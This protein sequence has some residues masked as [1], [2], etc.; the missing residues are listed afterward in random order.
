MLKIISIV[1][2]VLVAA[3][4]CAAL[5]LTYWPDPIF[6]NAPSLMPEQVEAIK[7]ASN[8]NAQSFTF[9]ER[10]FAVRD[11][12]EIFARVFGAQSH[13]TILL[14]HGVASDGAALIRPAGLLRDATSARVIAID[15]RGHGNSSGPAWDLDHVGKYDDDLADI[16][17]VLRK[18]DP[19]AKIILA[20]H[21][22]GGGIVLRYALKSDAP[23]IDGYLLFAPLLGTG[24]PTMRTQGTAGNASNGANF[25]HFRAPRLF[26]VLMLNLVGIQALN[27]LPILYFNQPPKYPAYGF[28]ALSS[29]QPNAPK[30]YRAAFAAIKAP[31]LLVAGSKDEAFIASA[32]PAVVRQYSRG[33]AIIVDG[34]THNSVLS[35]PRAIDAVKTWLMLGDQ[36]QKPR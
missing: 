26:G 33:D 34:A 31:L 22:M 14:V 15:L 18:E 6:K 10:R 7:A 23:A 4:F 2:V 3:Y 28:A 30:D 27:H 5:G 19:N 9:S 11:G 25:T 12:A 17:G 8:T 13:T 21:S 29:M 36:A 35:D 24:A 32:Y 1:F 16:A 20:G